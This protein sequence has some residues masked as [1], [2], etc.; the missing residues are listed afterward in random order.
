MTASS[1]ST[2]DRC[3]LGNDNYHH[4]TVVL[5]SKQFKTT[6]IFEFILD[7]LSEPRYSSII[8][9]EG[10]NGQFRF[11]E[12]GQVASLWGERNGRVNM[13][14]QKFSR[15]LRYY[16]HKNVLVKIRGRKYAYRFNFRELEKQYGYQGMT[17]PATSESTG[18]GSHEL[19]IPATGDYLYHPIT[20]HNFPAMDVS[21]AV[22]SPMM[23]M[24]P[25][26]SQGVLSP[27][28]SNPHYFFPYHNV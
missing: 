21:A 7:M 26:E 19:E 10:T 23:A 12:P 2:Y 1:E 6:K 13:T 20:E 27:S 3:F 24:A 5:P 9:W 11:I 17:F 18:P 16:Y 22:S 4:D 28:Y 15:A 8:S 14:Y 25:R